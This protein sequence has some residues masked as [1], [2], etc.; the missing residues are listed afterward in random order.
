MHH[1]I[2]LFLVIQF[3]L[4][5]FLSSNRRKRIVG[6]SKIHSRIKI[7]I[8]CLRKFL[9]LGIH[10]GKINLKKCLESTKDSCSIQV[11]NLDKFSMTHVQFSFR[12]A[13]KILFSKIDEKFAECFTFRNKVNAPICDFDYY[14]HSLCHS[15][16]S[17]NTHRQTI[18]S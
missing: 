5:P 13:S 4:T 8:L 18:F 10:I 7:K 1:V 14:F 2:S 3:C 17:V 6:T 12:S 11:G 9:M 15:I 16:F